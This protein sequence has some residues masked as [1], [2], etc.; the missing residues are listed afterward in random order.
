MRQETDADIWSCKV[1]AKSLFEGVVIRLAFPG[2]CRNFLARSSSLAKIIC[3]FR[4]FRENF[5]K[6]DPQFYSCP[7]TLGNGCCWNFL[8]SQP[9]IRITEPATPIPVTGWAPF[10]G[11]GFLGPFDSGP[12]K[13][14]RHRCR[15]E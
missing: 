1:L 12:S 4:G 10:L 2:C 11:H 13:A 8:E 6:V 7:A 15:S 9:S 3:Q 5:P 14:F